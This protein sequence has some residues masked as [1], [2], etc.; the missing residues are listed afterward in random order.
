MRQALRLDPRSATVRSWLLFHYLKQGRVAEAVDQGAVLFQLDEGGHIKREI[1][2]LFVALLNIPESR[3]YVMKR[4][5]DSPVISD[6]IQGALAGGMDPRLAFQ[7]ATGPHSKEPAKSSETRTLIMHAFLD[8]GDYE[9]AYKIWKSTLTSR[10]K[11]INFGGFVYDPNFTIERPPAPFAWTL[12]NDQEVQAEVIPSGL[13][14]PSTALRVMH[15]EGRDVVAAHQLVLLPAGSFRLVF[16]ARRV[17]PRSP[18][19]NE[20]T[21]RLKIACKNSGALLLSVPIDP[22]SEHDWIIYASNFDLSGACP[23]QFIE[24]ISSN[25]SRATNPVLITGIS[26]TPN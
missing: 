12:R 22:K 4:L 24:I 11:K 14:R 10:D 5:G 21:Y 26:I 13:N 2:A 3:V 6:V 18:L 19:V 8:A 7:L 1:T 23:A 15:F 20:H 16:L 25:E 17:G 9:G